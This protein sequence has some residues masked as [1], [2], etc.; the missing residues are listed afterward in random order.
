MRE[1]IYVGVNNVGSLLTGTKQRTTWGGSEITRV[2][3]GISF[4]I[5][6]GFKYKGKNQN[7]SCKAEVSVLEKDSS[8]LSVLRG[9]RQKQSSSIL[10][11]L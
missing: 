11:G 5:L 6:C 1:R 2:K 7:D 3:H 10:E 8:T 9:E 4:L